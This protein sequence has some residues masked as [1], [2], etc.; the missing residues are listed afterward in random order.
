M[1]RRPLFWP[2]PELR[3]LGAALVCS[4]MLAPLAAADRRPLSPEVCKATMASVDSPNPAPPQDIDRILRIG[5]LPPPET[6]ELQLKMEDFVTRMFP[7]HDWK[8][9]PIEFRIADTKRQN[10][11]YIPAKNGRPRKI[12]FTRAMLKRFS[13]FD[14]FLYVLGH[15][16]TH[17]KLVEYLGD[18][19]NSKGEEYLADL[20]PLRLLEDAGLDSREGVAFNRSMADS[21]GPT[22]IEDLIDVHGID[23]NRYR[24]SEKALAGLSLKRGG[25]NHQRGVR[26]LPMDARLLE[27]ADMAHYKEAEAQTRNFEEPSLSERIDYS[28]KKISRKLLEITNKLHAAGKLPLASSQRQIAQILESAADDIFLMRNKFKTDSE[29]HLE[30]ANNLADALLD[31][32]HQLNQ[33]PNRGKA[34]ESMVEIRKSWKDAYRDLS[35]LVGNVEG[36]EG[37]GRAIPLGRLKQ[38]QTIVDALVNSS[39]APE[40]VRNADLMDRWIRDHHEIFKLFAQPIELKTFQ[41]PTSLKLVRTESKVPWNR[42]LAWSRNDRTQS[43]R[44]AI[45][46]LGIHDPRFYVDMPPDVLLDMLSAPSTIAYGPLWFKTFSRFEL[47]T[48]HKLDV[49]DDGTIR[50]VTPV[51]QVSYHDEHPVHV[52]LLEDE[53][54]LALG[55]LFEKAIQGD[56]EARRLLLRLNSGRQMASAERRSLDE[57]SGDETLKPKDLI[58]VE[59]LEKDP[60]L[61][62]QINRE[63][64]AEGDLSEATYSALV[65]KF[66]ELLEEDPKKHSGLVR[67][68][69]EKYLTGHNQ[70]PDAAEPL[71]DFIL[72]DAYDL[73][74]L[75]ERLDLLTRSSGYLDVPANRDH[76]SVWRKELGLSPI[77]TTEDLMKRLDEI[78]A[79][80]KANTSTPAPQTAIGKAKAL[81]AQVMRKD[82][83]EGLNGGEQEEERYHFL[84]KVAS[85]EVLV[86][87]KQNPDAQIPISDLILRLSGPALDSVPQ[88]SAQL[89]ARLKENKVWPTGT[90][91]IGILWDKAGRH[92]L[93]DEDGVL[94][95]QLLSEAI[96]LARSE[97]NAALREQYA[98]RLVRNPRVKRP[99][100]RREIYDIW[101]EAVVKQVGLDD[102]SSQRGDLIIRRLER[103]RP[104]I[105]M[106]DRIELFSLLGR[107]VQAQR[108]LAYKIRD[109]LVEKKRQALEK[110]HKPGV[111]FEGGLELVRQSP[112]VAAELLE[113]LS[114]KYS[115][116]ARDAFIKTVRSEATRLNGDITLAKPTPSQLKTLMRN[117]ELEHERFWAAPLAIRAG[118]VDELL[119]PYAKDKSVAE[120]IYLGG[121][122]YVLDSLFPGT[123]PRDAQARRYL[124]GYSKVLEPYERS[125]FLAAMIAA[126][127]RAK[128]SDEGASIG[129]RLSNV[130]ELM[131]PAEVKLGQAMHSYPDMPEDI[132]RDMKH[133]KL[134]A[135]VPPVWEVW[136]L[137][138]KTVP[139]AMQSEIEHL[140]P[141]P[142]GSA[143]FYVVLNAKARGG[144]DFALALLRENAK[145]Q[146]QR[147]FERMEKFLRT[148]DPSDPLVGPVQDIIQQAKMMANV[149]VDWK[150]GQKQAKLAEKLYSGRQ[151]KVDGELFTFDTAKT[152]KAGDGYRWMTM[153]EGKH[154]IE[155]PT[156]GAEGAMRHKLALAYVTLEISNYL[157]GEHFDED[158]HA[159]QMKVKGTLGTRYDWGGINP[160]PPTSKDRKTF[161]RILAQAYEHSQQTGQFPDLA[162]MFRDEFLRVRN[163][164]GSPSTYLI[165]LQKG[166]L[167]LSDFQKG[168][169]QADYEEVLRGALSAGGIHPDI[170]AELTRKLSAA[171]KAKLLLSRTNGGRIHIQK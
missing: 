139:L 5:V 79:L 147:G 157:R 112:T 49:A 69:I 68:L 140:N 143:S 108:D 119:F 71:S 16:M 59:H 70:N 35:R 20:I 77:K 94:E 109:S 161:G 153:A 98:A 12:V 23:I 168:F 67:D 83:K 149:E 9:Q 96:R 170:S 63:T 158:A 105:A 132:S 11:Y 167:A 111:Q 102:K 26:P 28:P 10:A 73:F 54:E 118:I 86:F 1:Q 141:D 3:T 114:A 6:A 80:K 53:T 81:V 113:Y 78:D 8:A 75:R 43:L 36:G 130:F 2:P 93:F 148:L 123:S 31:V 18:G 76:L 156:T 159:G 65:D 122:K 135:N 103:L 152:I 25:L 97:P 38:L 19:D 91:E 55:P 155:L 154:F 89:G 88:L 37:E 42:F 100:L 62:I 133:T 99:V 72:S 106:D 90:K 60:N 29:E 142:L 150:Q 30:L 48:P 127:Q 47:P 169:T 45:I 40:A 124:I 162:Q 7:K 46:R 24:A 151:V 116:A 14:Q 146:S 165:G 101:T 4:F 107:R 44:R 34:R 131:G 136:D 145:N 33:M 74:T 17:H 171:Q 82:K 115:T 52:R 104:L 129:A 137:Y 92:R 110:S 126:S 164:G 32:A 128:Y 84:D 61:F 166:W 21:G 27:L 163:E 13:S 117:I 41:M 15:E 57:G 134:A 64:L 51:I 144:E 50:S 125:V 95:N 87:L 22:Q 39:S 66:D 121:F 160:K 58:G 56:R 120:Q 85:S 138:D